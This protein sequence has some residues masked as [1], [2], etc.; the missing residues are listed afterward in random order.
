MAHEDLR[1]NV[2]TVR[3]FLHSPAGDRARRELMFGRGWPYERFVGEAVVQETS[4]KRYEEISAV[5]DQ[6]IIEELR[7]EPARAEA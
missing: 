6:V 2:K 3:A 7:A 1:D 5:T 4:L